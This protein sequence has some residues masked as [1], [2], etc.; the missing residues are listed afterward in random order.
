MA[1]DEGFS[2]TPAT[3]VPT[4]GLDLAKLASGRVVEARVASLAEGIALVA[5]RHGTLQ[6]DLSQFG[7]RLPAV[8]DGVRLQVQAVEG[9]GKPAI[10]VVEH[11]PA[12]GDASAVRTAAEDPAMVLAQAV[13]TAAATQTG[14]APLYASLAGLAAAPQGSV[15]EP[16]RALVAQLMG[17]RLAEGA[18]PSAEAVRKAFAGSGIFLESRLAAAPGR[19]AAPAEDLKAALFSLRAA[20]EKWVGGSPAGP[21]ASGGGAPSGAVAATTN[22]GGAPQRSPTTPA[23]PTTPT[24]VA[25]SSGE[26][27]VRSGLGR[28][29]GAAYG[30]GVVPPPAASERGPSPTIAATSGGPPAIA[31]GGAT[32]LPPTGPV[33]DANRGVT[34]AP[35]APSAPSA[36]G[37][38]APAP[39]AA[40]T[41]TGSVPTS[42]PPSA[43]PTAV[44][45]PVGAARSGAGEAGAPPPQ[46]AITPS[47]PPPIAPLPPPSSP[48]PVRRASWWIPSRRW[49]WRR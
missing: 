47:P 3:A 8:G 18:P 1:V 22:S 26:G 6:V 9:G 42:P 27:G 48:S 7:D 25:V 28:L 39:P 35:S 31:T 43:V 11:T 34:L 49:T 4:S 29:A 41:P 12:S 16:V 15:P 37:V 5:S 21:A 45:G 2:V 38:P 46:S 33:T 23:S 19:A 32:S 40:S 36:P 17:A 20:L 14:L 13:R 44:A 30:G 10:T 24:T